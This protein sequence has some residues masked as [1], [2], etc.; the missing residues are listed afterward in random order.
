MKHL[1]NV[2]KR[3]RFRPDVYMAGWPL[4]I[5]GES[6]DMGGF[7]AGVRDFPASKH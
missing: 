5:G 7:D 4:T 2:G 1:E 6:G 3:A